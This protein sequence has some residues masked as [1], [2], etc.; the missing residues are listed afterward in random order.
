MVEKS[1]YTKEI[2][3]KEIEEFE[4]KH[5]DDVAYEV[6]GKKYPKD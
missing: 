2:Y 4:K 1:K 5:G 3:D 6:D